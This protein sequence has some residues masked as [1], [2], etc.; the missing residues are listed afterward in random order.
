[1]S[2][3]ENINITPAKLDALMK[4]TAGFKESGLL[5]IGRSSDSTEKTYAIIDHL[6]FGFSGI[7]PYFFGKDLIKFPKY[8]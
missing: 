5:F 4:A 2:F 8:I 6:N 1:M 7:F 3:I